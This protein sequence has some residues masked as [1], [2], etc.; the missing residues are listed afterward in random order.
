VAD[1]L[2]RNMPEGG[3][4]AIAGR[5]RTKLDAL[6]ARM[7]SEMPDV[8][9]PGV[10]VADTTDRESLEDLAR[11]TRV[12]ITTVGPYLEYGAPLVAACA[13]GLRAAGRAPAGGRRRR[14]HRPRV[15]GGPGPVHPG[16]HHPRR[17]VPRVR[18]AP[19]RG[20]RRG[21]HRLRGPRGRARVRGPHVPRAP[22]RG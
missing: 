12:V 19:R 2:V 17:P 21:R 9:P 15:A 3:A 8:P 18:R 22:G 14:R 13:D 11:S 20:L 6:A 1:Y 16:R 10:V 5:N 7:A 4:W